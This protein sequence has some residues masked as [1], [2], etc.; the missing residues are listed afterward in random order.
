MDY[1]DDEAE[2]AKMTRAE[3]SMQ[4]GKRCWFTLYE[5]MAAVRQIQW[6]IEFNYKEVSGPLAKLPT[7][8]TSGS[9]PGKEKPL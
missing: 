3:L 2:E 1:E 5:K 8:T 6:Y 9:S 4:V 7:F